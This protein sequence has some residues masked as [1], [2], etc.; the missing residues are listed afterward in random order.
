[1]RDRCGQTQEDDANARIGVTVGAHP[2]IIEWIS[3]FGIRNSELR[4]GETARGIALACPR[5]FPEF[6]ISDFEFDGAGH[7]GVDYT[8]PPALETLGSFSAHSY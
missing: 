6:G 3:E 7:G 5:P 2:D 4:R 1:L 8:N